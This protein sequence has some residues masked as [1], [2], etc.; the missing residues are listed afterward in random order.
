MQFSIVNFAIAHANTH[1]TAYARAR[2]QTA[3][4]FPSTVTNEMLISLSPWFLCGK[5]LQ[6]SFFCILHYSINISMRLFLFL[7]LLLY[8]FVATTSVAFVFTIELFCL[9]LRDLKNKFTCFD[10]SVVVFFSLHTVRFG[11]NAFAPVIA[12]TN[13]HAMESEQRINFKSIRCF[14]FSFHVK[15]DNYTHSM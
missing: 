11:F 12:M 6:R 4:F 2:N 8:R 14:F 9:C 5:S 7:F 10:Y 3:P 15:R 1:T 13:S